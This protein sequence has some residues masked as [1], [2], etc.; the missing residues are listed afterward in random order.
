MLRVELLPPDRLRL[1]VLRELVGDTRGRRARRVLRGGVLRLHLLP[2]LLPIR[3]LR[4]ALLLLKPPTNKYNSNN[5][6]VMCE[7]IYRDCTWFC[8]LETSLRVN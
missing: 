8:N 5:H 2:V 3:V 1:N 6:H 4:F 7:K